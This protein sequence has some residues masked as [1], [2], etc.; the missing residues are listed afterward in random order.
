MVRNLLE[1]A[2]RHSGGVVVRVH[3]EP[4]A[5][6][7]R[8]IDEDD[9]AGV[10]VELRERIFEPFFRPAGMRESHDRGVGVGLALVRQVARRHGGD[11]I[12]QERD[13]GGSRF[14]VTLLCPT[15]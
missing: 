6:G 11:V 10:P 12:C 7:A 1:N 5:S 8:L 2:R 13:D 15:I 3:V 4:T 14:V 9:G